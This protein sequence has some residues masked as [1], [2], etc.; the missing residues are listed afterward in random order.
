MD[1]G[2][3]VGTSVSAGQPLPSGN[4]MGNG[5]GE[6]L[7]ISCKASQEVMSSFSFACLENS[8]TLLQF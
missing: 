7:N 1:P 6:F 8:L 5:Q 2:Q 3:R 4:W